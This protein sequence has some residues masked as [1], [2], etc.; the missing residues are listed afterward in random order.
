[1]A[2]EDAQEPS[3]EVGGSSRAML[4]VLVQAARAVAER[5]RDASTATPPDSPDSVPT[6]VDSPK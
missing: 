6:A 1:M 2:T 3:V 4:A 5:L